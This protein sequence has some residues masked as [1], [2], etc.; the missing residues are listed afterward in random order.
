MMVL[1]YKEF[2][3]LGYSILNVTYAQIIMAI[4]IFFFILFLRPLLI[5]IV[6]K[7]FEKI[8]LKT[9]TEYDEIILYSLEKPLKFAFLIFAFY[10]LFAVLYIHNK[11]IN[12]VLASFAIF[13]FYWM[14]WVVVSSLDGMIYRAVSKVQ[15]ELSL[16][17]GKF[18]VR[19]IKLVVIIL[20]SASIL[21]VWGVNVTAL[22]ASLGIG[23]LA[24]ALA[25]KDTA[26]NLFGSIALLFDKSIKLGDW[27]IIDGIEGIVE[28]IGMRTTKI[29]TFKKSLVSIPNSIVANSYIENFSRRDIRRIKIYIGLVYDTDMKQLQAIIK[30]IKEMLKNHSGIDQDELTLVN[31]DKFSDSSKDILI[32]TF[33]NT[34]NWRR[35]LEIKEDIFYKIESIVKS[36][37]SD[38]AYPTS[39]IIIEKLPDGCIEF[40]LTK[41]QR[42]DEKALEIGL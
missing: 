28:D 39:S 31:F 40:E 37:G 13:D 4:F 42:G 18:F 24:F 20:G 17:L 22:I 36:H 35:Y 23:G 29:R 12:L 7:L 30:D 32:Y 25:A 33:T 26:S 2:P 41:Q 15:K 10:M 5:K 1:V 27:V 3:V 21:S 9:K 38:F 11:T 6:I 16:E 8:V 19:L 14:V 34:A